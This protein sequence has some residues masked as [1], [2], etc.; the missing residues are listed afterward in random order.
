MKKTPA[1]HIHH[2]VI[3]FAACAW[4]LAAGPAAAVDV[5]QCGQIVVGTGELTGD[6]D[7]SATADTA[8]YLQ[9]TLL[10]N[11]F[12]I[13]GNAVDDAV[14]C[15]SGPCKIA[16]PGTITGGFDGVRS[17]GGAKLTDLTID[18]NAGDGVRTDKSAKLDNCTVSNNA[19]DGIR[20]KA[21]AKLTATM[22]T[23]NGS[24][25]VRTDK[26][27]KLQDSQADGNAGA[28]VDSDAAAKLQNGSASGNGHDGVK[29]IKVILKG[30][31]ALGNGTSGDCGVLDECADVAAERRPKV[32][33]PAQCGISRDIENGGSWGVCSGD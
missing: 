19:G 7:C 15:E 3:V 9:G 10:M 23:G 13:T 22:V 21:S 6:L 25:G 29:A 26:S 18:A 4:A 33:D 30:T 27:A 24:D 11:G 20:S 28:G 5:T 31:Q 8:V 14:K 2:N 32:G 12:T 16:G 1:V 17:T